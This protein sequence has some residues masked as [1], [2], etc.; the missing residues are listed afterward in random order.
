[1]RQYMRLNGSRGVKLGKRR[2][3]KVRLFYGTLRKQ[4][5]VTMDDIFYESLICNQTIKLTV[6]S[7]NDKR[8]R[9]WAT[10]KIHKQIL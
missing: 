2:S 6:K 9:P 4:S 5:H 8:N 7:M 1:M 3:M 10:K